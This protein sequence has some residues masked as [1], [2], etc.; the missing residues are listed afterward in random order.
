MPNF[1]ESSPTIYTRLNQEGI[2]A[3]SHHPPAEALSESVEVR[4]SEAQPIPAGLKKMH[5][6]LN[7]SRVR[8]LEVVMSQS[9]LIGKL[10]LLSLQRLL[11]AAMPWAPRCLHAELEHQSS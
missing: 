8:C 11:A 3:A 7:V 6:F 2:A 4:A 10:G 1:S 5:S 9:C